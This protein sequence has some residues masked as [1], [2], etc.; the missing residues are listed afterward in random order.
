VKLLDS[1]GR[2]NYMNIN[3]QCIMEIDDFILFKN[4][5]WWDLWDEETREIVKNAVAKARNGEKTQFQA[6]GATTKG[7]HKWWDGIVSPMQEYGGIEKLPQILAISRDI[8]KQKQLEIRQS[9]LLNRFQSLVMQAPVA[10][11]VLRGTEY[12][13]EIIN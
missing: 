5:Y 11:C 8:T 12:L 2:L 6:P 10:I 9:E 4:K 1:E 7:T 3:G 13:I